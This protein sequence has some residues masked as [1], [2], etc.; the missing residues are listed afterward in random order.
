M[1]KNNYLYSVKPI[2]EKNM[3]KSHQKTWR[4]RVHEII[5]EADTSPGKIFDIILIVLILM[6]VFAVML[7]SIASI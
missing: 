5:F 7:D 6:S 2:T 3:N 4:S 1:N